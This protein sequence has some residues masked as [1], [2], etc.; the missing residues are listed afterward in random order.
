M[1]AILASFHFDVKDVDLPTKCIL[2]PSIENLNV[3]GEKQKK[4]ALKK[5]TELQQKIFFSTFGFEKEDDDN[6]DYELEDE[7]NIE[8]VEEKGSDVEMEDKYVETE[9]HL[10]TV[11]DLKKDDIVEKRKILENIVKKVIP[12]L[13]QSLQPTV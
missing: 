2:I 11:E 13:R 12:R 3:V 6:E 4:V 10:E 5:E 8:D 1:I 7:E 9:N